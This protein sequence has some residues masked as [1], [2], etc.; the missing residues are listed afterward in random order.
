MH[1]P[2]T[3]PL[4]ISTCRQVKMLVAVLS[5]I[6]LLFVSCVSAQTEDSLQCNGTGMLMFGGDGRFSIL[7]EMVRM[8][9]CCVMEK[10]TWQQVHCSILG[11]SVMVGFPAAHLIA[12]GFVDMVKLN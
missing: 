2:Q 11:S 6:T 1:I 3:R 12:F 8:V 10:L 9:V 5:L 4:S 7:Y